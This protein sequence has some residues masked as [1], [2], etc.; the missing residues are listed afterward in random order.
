MPN[1]KVSFVIPCYK[2]AH[3]LGECLE[4]ILSQSY[5]DFEI[6]VM[7]DC[8]PDNTGEVVASF[9]DPR[10]RYIRNNPNLGHLKNYNKGIE[11]SRGEYVWLISADDK[12]SKPYALERY[13]RVL[14]EHPEVGYAFCSSY[15]VVDGQLAEIEAYSVHAVEDRIFSGKM[16]LI[17]SLA[18]TNGVPAAA[19]MVRRGCYQSLGVFPLD[20][21]YAGDWFLWCLFALHHDVAYFA[22][23]MVEYRKHNLAMTSTLS[24]ENIRACIDDDIAV[25]YRIYK[26]AERINATNVMAVLQD[27]IGIQLGQYLSVARVRGT[28]AQ[29]T[30]Q[31]FSQKVSDFSL[32]SK[33]RARIRNRA[34]VL[35]GD[36]FFV[37]DELANARSMYILALRSRPIS[38]KIWVKT[39]LAFSEPCIRIARSFVTSIRAFSSNGT[40]ANHRE[41][42]VTNL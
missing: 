18:K 26:E 25:P 28:N 27:Q 39:L 42:D 2:L 6:L 34:L 1:P 19:G 31:E 4:S 12:I 38:P 24:R 22:E 15:S 36:R 3:Y 14:D 13:L 32:D 17:G 9:S 20:L 10:I 29:I 40:R 23:P 37:R 7:D 8:S 35:A 30:M 21:P 11:L 33:T 41:R 5:K 16:F